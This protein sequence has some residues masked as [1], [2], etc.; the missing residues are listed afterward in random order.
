MKKE[1]RFV[2]VSVCALVMMAGVQAQAAEKPNIVVIWGD[3]IGVHNISAYNHGIMGYQT[4][5]IDRIAKEGALFTDYYAQQSCTAGRAAFI[6]GQHP[7]R[8][9]LLTIGMPGS[10]HG[11]PDWAPTIAD[12]L[13]DQGY[14]SGQFGKNHLG[15]RDKHLPTV[16]GF[17]EFF[18]NLYHLN[19]EE[20]PE[21]YYYPKD[22]EFRKKFGP[23]GVLHSFADGKGG[24]TVKDTGP[25]TSKRME[26]VDEEFHAAAM[27]FVDRAVK[28]QKPFFLWYNTTR[29]H[30]W[31]RLKKESQGRTGI[32]LYPDGMV[33][34]DDMVGEVL[35]KL[36]DLGIADNTVVIYSTDNGAETFTW[37]DGGITPFHGE[38]GTTWEGGMRV[39][40]VVRWP[41]VIKPG[42]VVNNIMSHEDWMPTLLAAAGVPDVVDKL[43]TGYKANG[44]TFK[45]H[46]DGYNFLPFFQGKTKESP[47]HSIMYFGQGGEL[48]AVRYDDW[49]V[50]F[51]AVHGNIAFGER[52]VTNWPLIV[53]LRADPYEKMPFESAMYL[54]WYADNMW[55]FVPVQGVIKDF[56]DTMDEYPVQMGTSLNAAGINYNTLRAQA[57][58]ERIEKMEGFA[59]PGN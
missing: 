38:K 44:K 57:V 15:D 24:Q 54:R 59:L 41:G 32:G 23:R 35:K 17:D 46:A 51:A 43:K 18:G 19:A 7:F 45:I 6:L 36:D 12:L 30:V 53:N 33:E 8:T 52:R 50:N 55:L 10:D 5:N 56:L 14:V 31:T 21:T 1:L 9:G 49:K 11:I 28:S 42:T 4:P 27:D 22:P 29:M 25:L 34:H 20:E 26:T 48:N 3:D 40:C 16:H 37:P 58:M 39:P 13:K 47:R 2:L